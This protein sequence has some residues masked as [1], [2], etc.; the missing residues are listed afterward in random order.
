VVR[1]L[2]RPRGS[3]SAAGGAPRGQTAA[4]ESVL[5]VADDA[6]TWTTVTG[7]D[8][9][10]YLVAFE[11]AIRGLY[12][13]RPDLLLI[14]CPAGRSAVRLIES[15]R[16]LSQV[17]IVICF[18]PADG[19]VAALRAGAD[20]ALAK[21]VSREELELKMT[22]LLARHDPSGAV[23]RDGIV[24]LNRIEHRVEVG[25]TQLEL[26]PT[27]F[28]LLAVLM[29]RAG[30]VVS[31]EEI[32]EEVWGDAYRDLA[33]V[34]L[35]VSY[36]RRRFAAVGIDPFETVRGIGYRFRPQPTG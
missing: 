21:P 25:G 30:R 23:L 36:V 10:W 3:G 31:R 6:D 33:E 22:R 35:Y 20:D 2:G 4:G 17:P 15:V 18:E 16:I 32:L 12:D 8:R 24:A 27:E 5:L 26:T 34:K 11:H 19:S 1:Y 13:L 9:A 14:D 7:S 29:E 28:R